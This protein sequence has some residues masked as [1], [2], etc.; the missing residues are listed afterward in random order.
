[1]IYSEDG[2]LEEFI[3]M[4]CNLRLPAIGAIVSPAQKLRDRIS[5]TSR[6]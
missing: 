5:Y 4:N 1:M 2:I 6:Q 3:L